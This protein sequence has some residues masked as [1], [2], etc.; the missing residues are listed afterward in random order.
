MMLYYD[1]IAKMIRSDFIRRKICM[2]KQKSEQF[3]KFFIYVCTI[4]LYVLLTS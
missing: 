4:Y 2:F 1:V 3:F